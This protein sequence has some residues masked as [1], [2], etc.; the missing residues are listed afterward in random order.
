MLYL[1]YRNW[2]L[3]GLLILVFSL[4]PSPITAT[5]NNLAQTELLTVDPTPVN[6]KAS[7]EVHQVLQY[8]ASLYGEF[9]ISGQQDLTWYD[10]VDMAERVFADTDKYPAIMGY[11]F[12]NYHRPGIDEGN[13]LHQVE[14]AIAHWQRGG[15]ITFCWHWRDPSLETI[16]FYTRSTDFRIDLDDPTVREQLIHDIDQIATDLKRLEHA[17]VPVLWRPLHEASG[18]W[19]W[20]GASGPEAYIGLWRLMYERL[21]HHH[22]LNHLIWVYN[23]QDLDWYPGDAYVDIVGED[24]YARARLNGKPDFSSQRKR[25]LEA[26]RTPGTPKI[27]ALTE[28]GT[29]PD[30]N[31]MIADGAMW[32][33]FVTWND[34]IDPSVKESF[35]SGP[36][37]NPLSHRQQVYEHPKVLTLEQVAAHRLKW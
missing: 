12:M 3:L 22:G 33:Y 20:W 36:Q 2:S 32:S 8:L 10:E 17:G 4:H 37:H 14:E 19:F 11:D 9:I 21:T 26:A 15:L 13:G 30:P 28:N 1:R 31:A 24:V 6:A 25:F 34:V 23:A 5:P 18:G 27:V 35:W 29:I 16:A 7:Q